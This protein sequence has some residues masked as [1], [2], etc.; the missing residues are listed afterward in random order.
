M[1]WNIC[2]PPGYVSSTDLAAILGCDA[3]RINRMVHDGRFKQ[4][5]YKKIGSR[6]V[7]LPTARVQPPRENRQGSDFVSISDWAAIHNLNYSVA[8]QYVA[9][10]KLKVVYRQGTCV[11]VNRFAQVAV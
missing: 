8:R 6:Y 11:F 1:K 3:K 5:D 2:L 10:N 4:E 9:D 7:F